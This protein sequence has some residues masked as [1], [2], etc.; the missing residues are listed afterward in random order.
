MNAYV[1]HSTTKSSVLRCSR[2]A[3]ISA[4]DYTCQKASWQSQNRSSGCVLHCLT[5]CSPA[6]DRGRR[7]LWSG[8]TLLRTR[9]QRYRTSP[10]R[11]WSARGCAGSWRARRLGRS[12]SACTGSAHRG[13]SKIWEVKGKKERDLTSLA[14]SRMSLHN[15]MC[16]SGAQ[17]WRDCGV[18]RAGKI[19]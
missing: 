1:Y 7:F 13:G 15:P 6:S 19:R 12:P 2:S 10:W 17:V 8:G 3:L 4:I 11:C 5:G 18:C 16:P 9:S 14:F